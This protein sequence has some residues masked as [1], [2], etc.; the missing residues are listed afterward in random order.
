MAQRLPVVGGDFNAWGSIMNGFLGVTLDSLGHLSNTAAAFT[1]TNPLDDRY[2]A[3]GDGTTDDTTAINSAMAAATALYIPTGSTFLCGNLTPP[4]TL[5]YIF[6]GGTLKQKTANTSLLSLSS[7]TDLVIEGL[8]FTGV[9]GTGLVG[10][11]VAIDCTSCSRL[12][13]RDC[14]FT[15]WQHHAI[16][17]KGCVDIHIA[18][19]TV[20]S[21]SSGFHTQGGNRIQII[22]NMLR[23]SQVTNV[24]FVT[25][26]ALESVSGHAFGVP[27]DVTIAGNTIKTWVNSQAILCHSG[28]RVAITGNTIT[29]C[30]LG[31]SVNGTAAGDSISDFSITGNSV[32]GTST[33]FAGPSGGTGIQAVGVGSSDPATNVSITGNTVRNMNAI[34][35]DDN[36]GAIQ[37][38]EAKAVT[39]T[40]NSVFNTF[41][42]GICL[43]DNVTN[44]LVIGNTV[45]TVSAAATRA[46]GIL[47][48]GT[49]VEG[50]ITQNVVTNSSQGFRVDSNVYPKLVIDG[51]FVSTSVNTPYSNGTLALTNGVGQYTAGTTAPSISGVRYMEITSSA[52]TVISNFTNG[53]TGQE[54]TLAF[55]STNVTIT[56]DHAFLSGGVNFTST[57]NGILRLVLEQ[58]GNWREIV[59]A[60]NNS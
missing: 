56:R 37:A 42:A 29:D 18:G 46:I 23:D 10:G 35:L 58:D 11:N 45:D 30:L 40:G 25:V 51:N 34:A 14:K 59:R 27:T 15:G 19:N 6:G 60:V 2:G 53:I 5:K 22:G 7:N 38:H 21:C 50:K 36:T 17:L 52:G 3:V 48:R 24:T 20:Y 32:T 49:A 54:L 26:I 41:G 4:T 13:I 1:C 31:I 8:R 33:V 39:I 16:F 57:N 9:V 43:G 12:V 47:V 44:G 55:T 28:Q